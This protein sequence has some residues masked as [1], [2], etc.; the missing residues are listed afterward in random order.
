MPYNLDGTAVMWPARVEYALDMGQLH[1]V[2]YLMVMDVFQEIEWRWVNT[3][4]KTPDHRC[5]LQKK[6]VLNNTALLTV[7]FGKDKN[8]L[9]QV[10]TY[11]RDTRRLKNDTIPPNVGI[12]SEGKGSD[13]D[14]IM[15]VFKCIDLNTWLHCRIYHYF[16][17]SVGK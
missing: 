8:F 7:F 16:S 14:G 3:Q 10:K 9:E 15:E 13:D 5:K 2:K 4:A 12:S 17:L 1:L 6:R 11:Y